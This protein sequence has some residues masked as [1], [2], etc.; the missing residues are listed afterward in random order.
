MSKLLAVLVAVFAAAWFATPAFADPNP[1]GTYI[2]I[3]KDTNSPTMSGPFSFLV[4]NYDRETAQLAARHQ[5][6]WEIKPGECTPQ[7][8]VNAV[9][10]QVAVSEIVHKW[11]KITGIQ[12]RKWNGTPKDVDLDTLV[13]PDVIN[14]E[15]A[16]QPVM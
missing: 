8:E 2:Q 15:T 16:V 5:G 3:C 4:G 6:P 12:Y 1:D 14:D 9:D 7:I 10:G 13:D 11:F